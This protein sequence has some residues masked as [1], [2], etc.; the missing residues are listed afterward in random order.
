MAA[1]KGYLEIVRILVEFGA[2]IDQSTTRSPF[3]EAVEGGHFAIARLFLERG[4]K[5]CVLLYFVHEYLF[6]PSFLLS[7]ISG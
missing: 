5:V 3:G 7:T 6:I 1:H 2:E 4:L